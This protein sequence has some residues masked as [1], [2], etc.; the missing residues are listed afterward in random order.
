MGTCRH[1]NSSAVSTCNQSGAEGQIGTSR[2]LTRSAQQW[3]R[4]QHGIHEF[5]HGTAA[6]A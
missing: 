5:Q 3:P 2:R 1:E 4:V 6:E